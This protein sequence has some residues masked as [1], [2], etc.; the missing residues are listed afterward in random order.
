MKTRVFLAIPL[1]DSLQAAL[2]TALATFRAQVSATQLDQIRFIPLPNWH[3]TV[4]FFGDVP[5]EELGP[6]QDQ[7][8]TVVEAT[9]PMVLMPACL[10][11]A[12]PEKTTK[13]MVWLLCQEN[14]ALTELSWQLFRATWEKFQ[15]PKPRPVLVPHVTVARFK[16]LRTAN[17]PPLPP[18]TGSQPLTVS[19]CE[20]WA[21]HLEASGAVYHPVSQFRFLG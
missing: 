3:V 13:T 5:T 6:L 18:L 11:V 16:E 7:L 14:A 4:F 19:D 20:L 8:R 17:L 15:F 12:P 2:A 9:P 21:S 10:M 1:P